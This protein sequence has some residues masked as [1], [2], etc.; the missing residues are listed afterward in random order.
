MPVVGH[1]I[2]VEG[3]ADLHVVFG[4]DI[5]VTVVEQHAV[6][7][8]PQI[9][10]TQGVE[11]TAQFGDDAPEPVPASEKRFAAVQHDVHALKAVP[12]DMLRYT[13]GRPSSGFV[14]YDFWTHLPRLIGMLIY[15]T[16]VAR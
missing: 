6:R 12:L 8:H 1:P 3:D 15:I 14:R 16:V 7:V 13:A 10:V 4:E 9:K 2:A 5:E 11:V